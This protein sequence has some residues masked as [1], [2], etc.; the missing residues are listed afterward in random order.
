MVSTLEFVLNDAVKPAMLRAHMH[1]PSWAGIASA[2]LSPLIEHTKAM[3]DTVTDW[4]Y[5]PQTHVSSTVQL[6]YATHA[7]ETN[8]FTTG[9]WHCQAMLRKL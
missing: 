2:E 3:G 6:C 8:C 4:Y 5:I 1:P 9:G 7:Q